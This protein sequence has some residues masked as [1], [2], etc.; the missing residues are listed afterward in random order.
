MGP[1]WP[2]DIGVGKLGAMAEAQF[3]VGIHGVIANRGRI[4]ILRRSERM[5][6]C[7]GTWNLPG[8]HRQDARANVRQE[9]MR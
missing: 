8:E 2:A 1:T 7:P 5:G 3:F 9:L 4:L 6:Y